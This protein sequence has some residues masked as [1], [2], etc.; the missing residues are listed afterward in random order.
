MKDSSKKI[1]IIL[2]IIVVILIALAGTAAAMIITGQVAITAEQKLAKGLSD[3]GSKMSLSELEEKLKENE[4][5]YETPFEAETTITANINRIDLENTVG[6]EELIDE[7][8]NTINNSK[9]TNTVKAD[10]KNNLI[11]EN[12]KLNLNGIVEEIS[13]DIEYDGDQLS[14]RSKE[15]NE[16]Y[17]TFTKS[18]AELSEE[19]NSLVQIFDALE[20]ICKPKDTSL[21]LT[22]EEKA[23]FAE[24][25]EG[26]LSNYITEDMISEENATILLD[27]VNTKNCSKI[28][29]TLDKNQIIELFGQYLSKLESDTVGKQII[30]DKM[31]VLGTFEETDLQDYIDGLRYDI[32]SLNNETTIKFSLYCTMFKTYGFDF[33]I[34]EDANYKMSVI[35]GKDVDEIYLTKNNEE[36]LN[37]TKSKDSILISSQNEQIDLSINIKKVDNKDVISLHIK[38]L[39]SQDGFSITLSNEQISKT[40]TGNISKTT[41]E[42]LIES[43]DNTID[44]ELDIDSNIRYVDSIDSTVINSSNSID[45]VNSS[46]TELQEYID[47]ITNNATGMMQAMVENS[48][49][50]NMIYS[51]Y[52]SYE[53]AYGGMLNGD[54]SMT[55]SEFNSMFAN[56]TGTLTG[57]QA[58]RLL[59]QLATNNSTNSH[60]VAVSITDSGNTLLNSTDYYSGISLADSLI[61]ITGY[62]TVLVNEVDEAGYI[63]S[64]EI[65]KQ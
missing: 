65:R 5:L 1:I 31:S 22:K 50:V 17:I 15:L 37:I 63:T 42:F 32:L 62:Y 10:L 18:D 3:I 56:Y 11:V 51:I 24:Y 19:Y 44:F 39:E 40:A 25:Y 2:A 54:T 4:K 20:E 60:K 57:L 8:K 47:E 7:I 16:K 46:E 13:A 53:N 64:I 36:I 27:G 12:L 55:A 26:M 30:V 6:M 58:R 48:R 49:L 59:S 28:S 34:N 52:S 29:F 43:R 41:I 9:L 61:N 23:H 21:Y 35:F 38:E 14:L 45:L 33:E